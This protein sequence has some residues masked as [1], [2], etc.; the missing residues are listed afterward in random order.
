MSHDTP[1]L[2]VQR[3]TTAHRA[4]EQTLTEHGTRVGKAAFEPD[5]VIQT[6]ATIVSEP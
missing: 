4:R 5:A 6:I 1:R 3:E 2:P